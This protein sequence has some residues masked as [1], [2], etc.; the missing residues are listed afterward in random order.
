MGR[1]DAKTKNC[2]CGKLI[3]RRSDTC[4]S[5]WQVGLTRPYIAGEKN[6]RWI[7]GKP[8]CGRCNKEMSLYRPTTGICMEC[9][10]KNCLGR[11][12]TRY[13][14]WRKEVF[15]RDG[16]TCQECG[17]R[18]GVLN[19]DHIK[20]WAYYP[21]LRFD[22]NNGRTLCIDCHRQTESWGGREHD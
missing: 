13:I 17:I 2:S 8:N 18:G 7:G 9:K 3:Q 16:Y 1:S 15:D 4:K 6:H 5:C 19:A 21:E 12:S 11:T 10:M 22:R 20:S 14:L